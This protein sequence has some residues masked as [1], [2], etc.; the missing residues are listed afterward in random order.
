MYRFISI[1]Y[2][3]PSLL[4]FSLHSTLHLGGVAI[5]FRSLSFVRLWGFTYLLF[6]VILLL[7]I[8]LSAISLGSRTD[9]RTG[10]LL[11]MKCRWAKPK[12]FAWF[13]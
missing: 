4:F 11:E 5:P 9:R 7:S 12:S 10:K 1:V 6:T 3:F 2:L 8:A 13:G